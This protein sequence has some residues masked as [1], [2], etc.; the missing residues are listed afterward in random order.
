MSF[1]EDQDRKRQGGAC[2]VVLC[3]VIIED[4]PD[5]LH[6]EP[7]PEE[8]AELDETE[9]DLVV[10]VHRLDAAIRTEELEHLPAKLGVDLP[11]ERAVYELGDGDDYWDDDSEDFDGDVR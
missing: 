8:Q 6:R 7:D 10:R 9:E 2:Q 1:D 4:E 3:V 11:P 5:E